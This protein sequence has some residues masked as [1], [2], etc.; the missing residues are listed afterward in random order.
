MIYVNARF[1][2]QNITGAQRYAIEISRALKKINPDID[3]LTPENIVHNEL[4]DLF[5]AKRVGKLSGHFWEQVELP[6]YLK[7]QGKPLL[8]N[9]A[10]TAPLNYSNKVVVIHDLSFLRHPE[11]FSKGFYLCYSFLIPRIIRNSRYV[12]TV[13]EFSKREI[14]E[15]LKVPQ[16]K[17]KVIYNAVSEEFE[18]Q[19]IIDNTISNKYANYI[20][21]VSSLDPRKNFK[22][23]ILAFN[24]LNI[25]GIKLVVAGKE[26]RKVFND[27]KMRR[28]A[29]FT[30]VEF[31]G[32]VSD[33]QLAGLYK[34]AKLFVYPSFYEGF[35]L[36]PLEA[37][38]YGCPVIVSNLAS[39]PEVC[40]DAAYY[41]EPYNV[42]SIAEGIKKVL[43]DQ[44]LRED[45]IRKGRERI[46]SFNWDNSAKKLNEVLK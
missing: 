2:T 37:M 12:I 4:S 40:K 27:T 8:L 9:L 24:K 45:L 29:D 42:E 41:I 7:R 33:A 11:W 18:N 3:F 13:S 22:N 34:N 36:P 1:L 35:G 6:A 39:L 25:P 15:L 43:S 17:I 10:N 32:H 31:T 26:N 44:V 30:N 19:K 20:L 23:L 16:D 28:A 46:K 21:A 14:M 38:S 5:E